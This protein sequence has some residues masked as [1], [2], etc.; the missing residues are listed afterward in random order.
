M[1]GIVG[2]IRDA[3]VLADNTAA[4]TVPAAN[5]WHTATT[6]RTTRADAAF[7]AAPA[8]QTQKLVEKEVAVSCPV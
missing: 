4:E 6:N 1:E 8:F 2:V 3:A 5:A 7:F